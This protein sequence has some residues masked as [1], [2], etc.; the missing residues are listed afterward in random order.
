MG[1]IF[2]MDYVT[3]HPDVVSG[4]PCFA[5]TRVPVKSLFDWLANGHTIDEFLENFPSVTRE[6][7]QGVL[8]VANTEVAARARYAEPVK[9]R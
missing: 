3:K 7:A 1:K 4:T 6:Q 2:R 9:L 5:R 8:D